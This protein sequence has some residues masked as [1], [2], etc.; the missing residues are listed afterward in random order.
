M[1]SPRLLVVGGTGFVGSNLC[2]HAVAAGLD[3]TAL[4]KRPPEQ[5]LDG[6]THRVGDLADR[7]ALAG[8]LGDAAFEYVVNCGGYVDHRGLLDGGRE[9]ITDHFEGTQNLIEVLDRDQLERF[10]NIGSSD[11]YGS[12]PAPQSEELREAPISPYSLAKVASTHLLQM[13]GRTASFPGVT[14]RLF[15]TYGPG[16]ATNRFLPQIIRGCLANES[17]PASEGE[18]LRDLTHI[19]DVAAGVLRALET[20]AADGR[21]LN[22][23]SGVPVRIRDVVEQVRAICGG[24]QP[25]YGEIPYRPGESMTLWADA[26]AAREVLGWR[27]RL[28]LKAGLAATIE[29]YRSVWSAG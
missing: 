22:L 16:Q 20:P 29:H 5:P 24:G 7:G 11:E 26:T 25:R 17:F 12:A 8:A 6:V 27:P 2:R 13:L 19:D 4:S 3:V 1:V 14:I 18:Q 15:L 10:V 9:V 21:V 23:A 28:D